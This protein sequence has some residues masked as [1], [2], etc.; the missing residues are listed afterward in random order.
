MTAGTKAAKTAGPRMSDDAVKTKT[1]KAWKEWFAI[2]DRAGAGKMTHQEIVNYLH[3]KYDVPPWW[4]QTVTV[5]YEQE[6]GLRDK[7]QRPDGYQISVSR[8]INA[9]LSKLFKSV[10]DEKNRSA[11][12]DEKGLVVRKATA[13]KTMRVTWPD[14]K[15]SL[16]FYFVPKGDRKSQ[17]VVQHSKIVDAKTAA[18]MKTYWSEALDRLRQSLEA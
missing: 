9:P 2:L 15:Q 12:L 10:V 11:W 5:T 1:G 6:R 13:N 3:T 16:E 14:G 4:T 17:V 8:T 7:H 18:K